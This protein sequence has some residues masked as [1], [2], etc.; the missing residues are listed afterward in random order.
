MKQIR[1]ATALFKALRTIPKLSDCIPSID[2]FEPC[3]VVIIARESWPT[4]KDNL[5]SQIQRVVTEVEGRGFWVVAI[6]SEIVPGWETADSGSRG[7][8]DFERAI[9]KAKEHPTT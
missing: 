6:C 1:V 3:G 2:D 9:L 8:H 7:R 4:Q 5:P